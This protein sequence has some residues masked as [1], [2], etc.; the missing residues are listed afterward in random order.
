MSGEFELER[1]TTEAGDVALSL[2]DGN[3]QV[4]FAASPPTRACG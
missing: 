3:V 1:E 2:G 4:W